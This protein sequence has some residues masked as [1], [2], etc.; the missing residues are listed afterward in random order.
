[1]SLGSEAGPVDGA[2][3]G[4][5]VL[6]IDIGGTKVAAGRVSR[7]GAVLSVAR[8]PTP[9]GSDADE[10]F[11]V[12]EALVGEVALGD[13]VACGVGTCGPMVR[14]H[15]T[16]SP[17][18][19]PAWR[20]FPLR[21]R[22]AQV[23]ALPTFIDGDGK[24]LALAEGWRGAARHTSSYVAMVVSTGVGGGI[25]VDGRLLD[26]V[27]ANA[28]HIGHIVVEPM[29]ARCACGGRG[30]LEAEVSGA[31]I[32]RTTGRPAQDADPAARSR[33]GQLVGRAIAS[34]VNLVDL[35]LAVI[36][37]SVALGFGE[38][39]F[40]AARRELAER[41]RLLGAGQVV[42]APSTL[43]AEGPLIG[44]AAVGWRGAADPT[45][46]GTSDRSRGKRTTIW[47]L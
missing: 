27:S 35:R 46:Q 8:R 41:G 29:G 7:D 28:G 32:A 26:G 22:V 23:T 47:P 40:A 5:T 10:V 44:A 19:I 9:S 12:I 17:L 33:A 38:P 2:G 11:T 24:A 18:N 20:D 43:G 30:C 16:I 3:A 1:M 15:E 37:G 6:A 42:I 25:V 4:A 13:E 21:R 14:P 39:F 36:S 34:V 45:G 31:A